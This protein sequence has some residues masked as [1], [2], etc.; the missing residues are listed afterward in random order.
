M[1]MQVFLTTS[2]ETSFSLGF[3]AEGNVK[4]VEVE[5]RADGC[6]PPKRVENESIPKCVLSDPTKLG[7]AG[8]A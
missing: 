8:A 4:G 2:L 6:T 3:R 1:P 7:A 5:Q